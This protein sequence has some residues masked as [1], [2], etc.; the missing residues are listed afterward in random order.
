MTPATCPQAGLGER[1]RLSFPPTGILRLVQNG[2][3]IQA[4]KKCLGGDGDGGE[5]GGGGAKSLV[6]VELKTLQE[7]TALLCSALLPTS[8]RSPPPGQLTSL[9]PHQARFF[10]QPKASSAKQHWI[11]Q[12]GS[13]LYLSTPLFTPSLGWRA[14]RFLHFPRTLLY[15]S[16]SPNNRTSFPGSLGGTPRSS[17]SS[18]EQVQVRERAL[19]LTHL[20]RSDCVIRP[21]TPGGKRE[22]PISPSPWPP[23]TWTLT[24]LESKFS[25][26]MHTPHHLLTR[27]PHP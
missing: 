20:Y 1:L 26:A 6:Q 4:S 11:S 25:I 3:G 19:R 5:G 2:K 27:N 8:E 13:S 16:Y 18:C 14:G 15:S 12:A 21:R 9:G 24:E 22:H 23:H 7:Q 17:F 10:H